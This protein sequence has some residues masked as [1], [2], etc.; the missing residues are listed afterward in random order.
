MGDNMLLAMIL[1]LGLAEAQESGDSG[2]DES[3]ETSED[4]ESTDSAVDEATEEATKIVDEKTD[5][6]GKEIIEKSLAKPIIGD[7]I[8]EDLEKDSEE[9]LEV[10]EGVE[11]DGVI[12]EVEDLG[13]LTWDN[14]T[15]TKEEFGLI[16]RPQFGLTSLQTAD[17]SYSGLHAGLNVGHRKYHR[18]RLSNVGIYS[19]HRTLFL[20]ILGELSGSEIRVGSVLGMKISVL[21]A[22]AG[23]DFIRHSLKVRGADIDYGPSYGV[24][25]PVQVLLNFDSLKLK[26]KIE[27][28]WYAG[29]SRESVDWTEHRELTTLP[30]E[31]LG[32]EFTWAIGA[33]MGWFGLSYDQLH[34]DQGIQ[35]TI[36]F[37]LQR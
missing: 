29:N 22:E 30:I 14:L 10:E 35:R 20:A 1:G 37:G 21:E 24:A 2:E 6:L 15:E 34:M 31:A 16:F 26:V 33:R 12:G 25:T 13:G 7:E 28:R 19:R 5:L 9:D 3:T 18:L 11:V 36:S 17:N 8:L 27:P 4:S 23:F 32:D